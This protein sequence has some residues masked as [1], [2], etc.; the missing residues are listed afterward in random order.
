[1]TRPLKGTLGRCRR[2]SEEKKR[3]SA[4][5]KSDGFKWL[6]FL[7]FHRDGDRTDGGEPHLA[8][9]NAGNQAAIDIVVMALVRSF[10]AVLLGQL[11][12]VALELVDRADVNAV[13]ADDFHVLFDVGRGLPLL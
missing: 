13:G 1:M 2:S 12:P 6:R 10:S 7:L 11:D 3:T 5:S 4:S 8:A 9:F